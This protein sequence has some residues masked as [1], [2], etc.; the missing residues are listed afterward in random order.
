MSDLIRAISSSGLLW[1]IWPADR[2]LLGLAACSWLRKE[3]LPQIDDVILLAAKM[4]SRRL[5][6]DDKE[7]WLYEVF[8]SGSIAQAFKRL[9]KNQV[10]MRCVG[11]STEQLVLLLEGISFAASSGWLGG[12]LVQLSLA[13][14]EEAERCVDR[15]LQHLGASMAPCSNL[16]HLDLPGLGI[17]YEGVE[18]LASALTN[19]TKLRTLVLSDNDIQDR[20][21]ESVSKIVQA[22]TSLSKL[23]LEN[24]AIHH[25]DVLASAVRECFSLTDLNVASNPISN[26]GLSHLATA[27]TQN[28]TLALVDLNFSHC[29]LNVNFIY[30]DARLATLDASDVLVQ[31]FDRHC[32]TLSRINLSG[33]E[34]NT[35]HRYQRLLASLAKCTALRAVALSVDMLPPSGNDLRTLCF[36]VLCFLCVFFFCVSCVSC[37]SDFRSVGMSECLVCLCV[38]AS[39][40]HYLTRVSVCRMCLCLYVWCPVLI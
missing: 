38:C 24:T 10:R 30:I 26:E 13:L 11:L 6:E 9:S 25:P 37:A 17:T 7:A 39:I 5:T 4:P 28:R 27:L 12:Q 22:C 2:V 15:T 8:Q 36:C 34:F 29:D 35:D 23:H 18:L 32:R 3:L 40:H 1:K 21:I 31:L 16:T 19:C 14:S 20:G 33:N